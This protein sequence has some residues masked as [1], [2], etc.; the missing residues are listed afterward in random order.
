MASISK[1][2]GYAHDINSATTTYTA[3]PQNV[4]DAI[5]EVYKNNEALRQYIPALKEQ[6]IELSSKASEINWGDW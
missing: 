3:K 5:V 4:C 6:I 2:I 1:A